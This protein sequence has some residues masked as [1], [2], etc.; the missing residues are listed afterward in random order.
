[1]IGEATQIINGGVDLSKN[2]RG[3]KGRTSSGRMVITI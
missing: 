3:S 1:M 2:P